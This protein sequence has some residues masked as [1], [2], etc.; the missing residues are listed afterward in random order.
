MLSQPCWGL[1][2]DPADPDP[3]AVFPAWPQTSLVTTDLFGHHWVVF[4]LFTITGPDPN[5]QTDV[6]A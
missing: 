4:D 6:L 2:M 3:L 5:L 1:A